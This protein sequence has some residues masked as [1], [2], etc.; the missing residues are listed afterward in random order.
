MSN[1]MTV[2][3]FDNPVGI[4]TKE[5]AHAEAVLHRAFSVYI[6][7]GKGNMLL[8]RRAAD[9]YHS[10]GLWTNACCSH[11]WK[12][13]SVCTQA[14]ERLEHELGISCPL[15]ELFTYTYFHRFS[16]CLAEYEYD[17]ILAGRVDR[18]NI[19]LSPS[20]EEVMEWK[21]VPFGELAEDILRDPDSYSVWF[22]GTVGRVIETLSE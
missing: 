11:P 3:A 2:D 20:P 12:N 15:R 6:H 18:E 22:L 4:M 8:Q 21:W 9:K 19:T 13:T 14:K 10:G 16:P 17:H 5:Q 7:D 1:V